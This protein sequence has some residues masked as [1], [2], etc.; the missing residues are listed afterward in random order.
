MVEGEGCSRPTGDPCDDEAGPTKAG[1]GPVRGLPEPAD[2]LPALLA[3]LGRY[4][5]GHAPD[6]VVVLLREEL[7]RREFQAYVNG[8]RDAADE[9]E[10]VL[11]EAR[12]IAQSRRLRLVGRTP[13]QAAVIPFPQGEGPAEGGESAEAG[14][15][16]PPESPGPGAEVSASAARGKRGRG[17]AS[18]DAGRDPAPTSSRSRATNADAAAPDGATAPQGSR[19][20]RDRPDRQVPDQARAPEDDVQHQAPD[21]SRAGAGAPK[22]V[23]KSRSSRVPTIPRL[24]AR[25]RRPGDHP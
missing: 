11:E 13:G 14:P 9:Y 23:A 20:P 3:T 12:R 1:R 7:A 21:A 10:P 22:L 2:D 24:P 17:S 4:L 15:D 25:R 18:D 16:T 6:E 5:E 8:W 19:H